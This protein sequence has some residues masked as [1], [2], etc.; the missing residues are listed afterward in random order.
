VPGAPGILARRA[1]RVCWA[2]VWFTVWF[3]AAWCGNACVGWGA[4]GSGPGR[5]PTVT[6]VR[7]ACILRIMV[8]FTAKNHGMVYCIHRARRVGLGATADRD[9]SAFACI[10]RI[11]VWFTAPNHGCLHSILH[12]ACES[13]YG[14]IPH[15]IMAWFTAYTRRRCAHRCPSAAECAASGRLGLLGGAS[16]PGTLLLPI[17]GSPTACR[18]GSVVSHQQPL[19]RWFCNSLPRSTSCQGDR[20]LVCV[21]RAAGCSWW[22]RPSAASC[23][24]SSAA[25]GCRRLV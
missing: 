12:A 15:R 8:W 22:L 4:G 25:T 10:L 19:P 1:W 13:W 2:T 9:D 23:S 14:F 11:M 20:A 3:T 16:V 5:R 21:G 6:K 24:K 17:A 7:F 18:A